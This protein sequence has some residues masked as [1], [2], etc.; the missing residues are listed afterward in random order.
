[1]S[2]KKRLGIGFENYVLRH[3]DLF[4]KYLFAEDEEEIREE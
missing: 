4:P 2:I 1:L 3:G